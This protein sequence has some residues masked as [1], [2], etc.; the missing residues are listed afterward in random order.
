MSES[1]LQVRGLTKRYGAR[2]ACADVSFDLVPGEVLAIVGESGS[3]KSTLLSLIAAELAP[4]SGTVAYRMRDG[5]LRDLGTLSEAGRRALMRTEWGFVRQDAAQGLRMAVSAGGNVGERLMGLGERHYGR[6]R[7]QALDWLGRVEIAPDRIDD[8]PTRFSG[9]MRQRLQIAR[10]LVTGPRLV[11]MDEPTSGLD[12][13][14]QARL[15]DLIRRL[16]AELGLA[17]IIVTHDLAVARLLSHRIMVMRAGRVIE[18]GLTDRVLD[19]PEHAY[20]QLLVASV[21]AA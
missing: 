16:S 18:T 5:A 4:D 14:V 21:L 19:D 20:T 15:L 1:L 12:V 13:S 17:V 7:A 8:P 6:I 11:L 10:N 2:L 9:G 3:G